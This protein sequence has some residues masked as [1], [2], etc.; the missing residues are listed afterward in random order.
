MK[1]ECWIHVKKVDNRLV[2]FLNGEVV[3]DSGIV[4]DDPDLNKHIEI[5]RFLEEHP[6]YASELIFEGFNDTYDSKSD[7]DLNPWHFSYRVFERVLDDSGKV[8]S[9]NDLVNPYDEKHL[10]NPNMRAINNSYKLV[11]RNDGFKVI[12]NS[13]SQQFFK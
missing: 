9:E 6:N 5:T 3:W 11:K 13:L 12:G 2:V 8:I 10:S 7:D 4:H 1:R